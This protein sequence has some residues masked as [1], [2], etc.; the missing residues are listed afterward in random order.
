MERVRKEWEAKKETQRVDHPPQEAALRRLEREGG[1]RCLRRSAEAGVAF[2]VMRLKRCPGVGRREGQSEG[3]EQVGWGL[4]GVGEAAWGRAGAGSAW[5][6]G[7]G[8]KC[9]KAPSVAG[10]CS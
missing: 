1:S 6:C 4:A 5:G 3:Q 7:C 9:G 10:S 2:Q 8:T